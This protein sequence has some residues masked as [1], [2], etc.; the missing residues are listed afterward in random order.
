MQLDGV[1]NGRLRSPGPVRRLF[2]RQFGRPIGGCNAARVDL[3]DAHPFAPG[4]DSNG[5]RAVRER[6]LD[7]PSRSPAAVAPEEGGRRKIGRKDR[8]FRRIVDNDQRGAL[9]ARPAHQDRRRD[10]QRACNPRPIFGSIC[11]L[12]LPIFKY[13]KC[14]RSGLREHYKKPACSRTID[15]RILS[16]V[17]LAARRPTVF[18]N[19]VDILGRHLRGWRPIQES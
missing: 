2:R 17:A 8:A 19:G 9:C 5:R 7:H 1:P 10:H 3:A 11:Q 13:Y 15:D 14:R 4:R 6:D 12:L 16:S 18:F